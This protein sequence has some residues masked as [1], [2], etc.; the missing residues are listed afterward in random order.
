VA[1][2][3]PLGGLRVGGGGAQAAAAASTSLDP[4]EARRQLVEIYSQKDRSKL[5]NVEA[6]LRE[7]KG[8][9]A[10]LLQNV[11][12]KHGIGGAR[13][14]TAAAAAAAAGG[15][16]SSSAGPAPSSAWKTGAWGSSS[17]SA[18]S[19]AGAPSPGAPV[20]ETPLN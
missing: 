3:G 16:S 13:A 1:E 20:S 8:R 9:E 15:G 7:W 10:V 18:A 14:A 19:V 12:A 17:S 5:A 4:D 2:G 11:R 6:L